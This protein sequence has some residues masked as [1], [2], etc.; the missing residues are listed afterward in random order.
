MLL[1]V[2]STLLGGF[3]EA[4][5]SNVAT[6][7]IHI[8]VNNTTP[9]LSESDV[10]S[11]TVDLFPFDGDQLSLLAAIHYISSGNKDRSRRL[12]AALDKNTPDED[13]LTVKIEP[14]SWISDGEI[15]L[16]TTAH[17]IITRLPESNTTLHA[18]FN[19]K[20]S[21]SLRT[22]EKYTNYLVTYTLTDAR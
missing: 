15:P 14:G 20:S 1:V 5:A 10:S 2:A 12:T 6:V 17:D 7:I 8:I 3:S 4:R 16:S 19:Y 21:L 22:Y 18:N 13:L 11:Y 9:I